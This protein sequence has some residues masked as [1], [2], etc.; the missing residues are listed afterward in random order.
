MMETTFTLTRKDLAD[1]L[2]GM[3]GIIHKANRITMPILATVKLSKSVGIMTVGGTNLET[4]REVALALNEAKGDNMAVCV[5]FAELLDFVTKVNS[6]T[7]TFNLFGDQNFLRCVVKAPA[8]LGDD[9]EDETAALVLDAEQPNDFP[10]M[11]QEPDYRALDAT[12]D[13]IEAARFCYPCASTSEGRPILTGILFE[14]IETSSSSLRVVGAAATDGFRLAVWKDEAVPGERLRLLVPARPAAIIAA[15]LK[16]LAS[17]GWDANRLYIRS[18]NVTIATTMLDG[19]FPDY[20]KIIPGTET[21]GV[22]FSASQLG[23][24]VRIANPTKV[25]SYIIHMILD[26]KVGIGR[27]LV[28]NA[29][30]GDRYNETIRLRSIP[31]PCNFWRV[32]QEHEIGGQPVE[33]MEVGINGKFLASAMRAYAKLNLRRLDLSIDTPSNPI[34]FVG[35]NADRGELNYT[36]I[37]MPMSVSGRGDTTL[38]NSRLSL[39]LEKYGLKEITG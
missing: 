26:G 21:V 25:N 18:G 14:L 17:I 29:Y 16:R 13:W 35:R 34:K 30:S 1:A 22:M 12:E 7:L 19:A 36:M 23:K 9:F 31:V 6:G 38:E 3:K 28:G 20:T 27:F 2:N 15:D 24:A 37:I 10:E 33:K 4:Y 11:G 8:F 32:G 5:D 39:I